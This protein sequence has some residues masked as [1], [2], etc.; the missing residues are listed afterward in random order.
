MSGERSEWEEVVQSAREKLRRFEDLLLDLRDYE[1]RQLEIERMFTTGQ[2]D[3]GVYGELMMELKSKMLPLV[4]EYFKLKTTLVELASRLRV[5]LTRLQVED[6]TRQLPAGSMLEKGPYVKQLMD[7]IGSTLESIENS[8]NS[9]KVEKELRLLDTVIDELQKNEALLAEWRSTVS[10]ILERWAKERFNYASSIE[11]L[12]RRA[13]E[14]Q[15]ALK[16]V[17]VRFMVGEFDRVEYETKR[18]AMEREIGEV[19]SRLEEM[20]LKLEDLDLVAAR[21][22][23]LVGG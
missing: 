10:S 1:K 15:E 14:L 9:V 16:E 13:E 12:E 11:D 21:C 4:E 3:R 23:S 22:R 18:A 19:Q 8:L 6:K 7:R 17:E 20:Q 5:I 2:I